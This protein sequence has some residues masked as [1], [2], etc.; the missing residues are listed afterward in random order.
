[1]AW[2]RSKKSRSSALPGTSE[3]D[4]VQVSVTPAP[5]ADRAEGTKQNAGV[6]GTFRSF[7][8]ARA[9]FGASYLRF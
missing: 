7:Y 9:M 6:N 8:H 3:H 4:G 1:M 2:P 5:D